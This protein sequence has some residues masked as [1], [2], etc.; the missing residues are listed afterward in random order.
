MGL[1]LKLFPSIHPLY[2]Q[3]RSQPYPSRNNP[4]QF[5]KP[6]L[7]LNVFFKF[8]KLHMIFFFKAFNHEK[9]FVSLPDK[10]LLHKV[11]YPGNHILFF[12]DIYDFIFNFFRQFNSDIHVNT[13][14]CYN[15]NIMNC[16]DGR[17]IFCVIPRLPV[18]MKMGNAESR[19][20][21]Y[22]LALS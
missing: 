10:L 6:F 3:V 11:F 19:F 13:S 20:I 7:Y 2:L 18:L 1:W 12:R 9:I 4:F 17:R 15:S 22:R 16:F 8:L 5:R 21:S 14:L